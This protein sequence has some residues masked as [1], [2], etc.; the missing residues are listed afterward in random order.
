MINDK[1]EKTRD[2]ILVFREPCP[3]AK[4]IIFRGDDECKSECASMK[5][6]MRDA[7][8]HD[9]RESRCAKPRCDENDANENDAN[10]RARCS[11]L[12]LF[13]YF[14]ILFESARVKTNDEAREANRETRAP[15][16]AQKMSQ[17][18]E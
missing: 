7:M 10:Q 13:H 5:A 18:K 11:L 3:C 15:R 12:L 6:M 16:C 17:I 14:F 9:A 4:K 1:N 8:I 2:V